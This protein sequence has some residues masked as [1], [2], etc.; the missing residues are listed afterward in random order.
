MA[1]EALKVK[2]RGIYTTALTK[3][4][5]DNGFKIV[6]PSEIIRTRFKIP[7][8]SEDD[9]Q[10]DIEIFDKFDRQGVKII[11][12]ADAANKIASILLN[13]LDDVII[14][15]QVQIYTTAQPANGD[16]IQLE[17]DKSLYEE[18]INIV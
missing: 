1:G 6:Q 2:V 14:R 12:C 16:T 18:I 9:C 3:I 11:G 7:A 8:T 15:R 4:L 17:S 13:L 10:P 5:L